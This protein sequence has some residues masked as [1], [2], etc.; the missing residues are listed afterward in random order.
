MAGASYKNRKH[1]N[2][3]ATEISSAKLFSWGEVVVYTWILWLLEICK[4]YCFTWS[5]IW[6][7]YSF[8]STSISIKKGLSIKIW[9]EIVPSII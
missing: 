6:G 7:I 3:D 9:T 1:F 5:E 2:Y 8:T 4:I